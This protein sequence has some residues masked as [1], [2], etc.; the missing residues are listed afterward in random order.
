MGSRDQTSVH[1]NAERLPSGRHNLPREFVVG[2]QRDRVL[3]AVATVCTAKGYSNAT[4]TMS[5]TVAFE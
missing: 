3:D 5:A 1:G 2:S 4:V